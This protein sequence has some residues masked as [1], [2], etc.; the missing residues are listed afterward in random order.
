MAKYLLLSFVLF[1][2]LLHEGESC[3]IFRKIH[4]SVVNELVNSDTSLSAHCYSRNDD[5]GNPTI[6]LNQ[7]INFSFCVAPIFTLF[8][9]ELV[10]G[11][12]TSTVVVY[13]AAWWVDPCDKGKCVYYVTE[14]GTYIDDRLW[15]SWK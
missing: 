15:A 3:F 7:E 2:C 11:E 13:S 9:C 8:K 10:W 12:R 14:S 4:V 5:L 1:M 6:P